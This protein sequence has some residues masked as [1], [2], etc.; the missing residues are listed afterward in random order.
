MEKEKK[1][2]RKR[3]S[4]LNGTSTRQGFSKNS[5]M[6]SALQV[7][8]ILAGVVIGSQI[9]KFVEKKD[10]VSGTDLLGLDGETSKYTSPLAVC[11]AGA[12]VTVFA[13]NKHLKNIALGLTVAGGAGLVNA[14]SGKS[15]VALGD[16]DENAPI[17]LPGIG[18]TEHIPALPGIGE[19]N[20]GN[21]IPDNYDYSLNPA[22][23]N[24]PAGNEFGNPETFAK[25][26]EDSGV[27]AGIGFASIL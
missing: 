1:K 10:A 2:R 7:G 13:P 27:V 16:T 26:E 8:E 6:D 5:L 11:L 12:V 23:V 17:V 15:V 14:I 9:K 4:A 3:R 21:A 22:L 24:Q 19:I 20:N 25:D 18:S